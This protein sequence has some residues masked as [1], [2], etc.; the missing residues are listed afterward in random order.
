MLNAVL[1][2]GNK[3]EK[4]ACGI[5]PH[6]STPVIAGDPMETIRL[7]RANCLIVYIP[8]LKCPQ[9]IGE[10]PLAERPDAQRP[11]GCPREGTRR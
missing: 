1:N 7:A 10:P 8:Q 6:V 3:V 2:E 9:G 5:H 4:I 11:E